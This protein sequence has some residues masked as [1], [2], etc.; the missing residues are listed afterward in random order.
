MKSRMGAK[1]DIFIEITLSTL[2]FRLLTGIALP[3][4]DRQP[5]MQAQSIKR[6]AGRFS[7]SGPILNPKSTYVE[8]A[9]SAI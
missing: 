2:N 9:A 8:F 3:D 6:L 4:G 7:S 1:K 5:R